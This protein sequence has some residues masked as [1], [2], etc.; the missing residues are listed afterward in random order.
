M[1]IYSHKSNLVKAIID[2]RPSA[3]CK[4]PYVA[5]ITLDNNTSTLGHTPAL[6]CCG[7]NDKG[8]QVYAMPVTNPKKC[9][10]TIELALTDDNILVGTN[11]KLAETLVENCLNKNYISK[12]RNVKKYSRE[13]TFKNSRFDFHGFDSNNVEFIMEVKS[14]PLA[15]DDTRVKR[16]MAYFPDGYRKSKK[17]TISPRALKHVNELCEIKTENPNIRCILCFVIQRD[18]VDGFMISE[19]DII[20]REAVMDAYVV[21]VE[22]ISIVISWNIN[23]EASFVNMFTDFY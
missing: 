2:K 5:D 23:G 18:D 17:D 6:G 22:V 8:S 15:K 20:Y 21:G 14:V 9:T 13:K 1:L 19:D 10:H 16:K 12:L 7:L 3:I 4:T 11:P